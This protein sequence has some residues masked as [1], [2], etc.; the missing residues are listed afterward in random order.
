ML[1]IGI[2]K[3]IEVKSLGIIALLT[4]P[5]EGGGCLIQLGLMTKFMARYFYY[6]ASRIGR[7]PMEKII[8]PF[9]IERILPFIGYKYI[10]EFN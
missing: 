5:E 9:I 8:P 10:D 3:K 7:T 6:T 2:E 1:R 4:A